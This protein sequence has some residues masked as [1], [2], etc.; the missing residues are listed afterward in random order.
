[1][2]TAYRVR[3]QP[4]RV[5]GEREADD[6]LALDR[7]A[8]EAMKVSVLLAMLLPATAPAQTLGRPVALLE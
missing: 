8:G 3:R 1:V 7:I 2:L 6:T 5:Y 4:T